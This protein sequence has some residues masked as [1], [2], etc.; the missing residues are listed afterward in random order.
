MS[1]CKPAGTPPI[2]KE[3]RRD[4]R[5]A[6]QR[7]AQL[8]TTA[9]SQW[10]DWDPLDNPA[11]SHGFTSR[12]EYEAAMRTATDANPADDMEMDPI[13]PTP[14]E[15]ACAFLGTMQPAPPPSH[16]D[17]PLALA[18][19]DEAATSTGDMAARSSDQSGRPT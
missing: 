18:G 2:A 1:A 10:G 5:A 7:T 9:E 12:A 6:A 16:D 17:T 11:V 13:V 14:I 4:Q 8:A 15:R 3:R 19:P